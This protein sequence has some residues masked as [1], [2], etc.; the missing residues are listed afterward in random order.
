MSKPKNMVANKGKLKEP[1]HI[2]KTK[3]AIPSKPLPKPIPSIK[4]ERK[5]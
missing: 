1:G 4:H 5:K 3:A 2:A